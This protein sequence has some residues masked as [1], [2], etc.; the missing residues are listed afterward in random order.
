MRSLILAS[1]SPRRL[2]LLKKA[3]LKFSVIT[4]KVS[5]IIDKNL[6]LEKAVTA[7]ARQKIE[8][9]LATSRAQKASAATVVGAD[10]VVE[11]DGSILG[12]PKSKEEAIDYLAR[13]SGRVHRVVTGFAIFDSVTNS[14][15][16]SSDT[17]KVKFCPLTKCE[18]EAYV[19]TGSPMDKAGAYG[20]QDA[21]GNFISSVEGAVDNVMGL[22][23]Y[24]ILKV[25]DENGWKFN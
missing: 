7:L 2:E 19:A 22:P 17:S 10:T 3:G 8:A 18:I 4:L 24:K 16:E 5:E 14:W 15:V 23:V 25:F 21:G 11:L 9:V 1:Q 13:L 12:K 6:T 20:I